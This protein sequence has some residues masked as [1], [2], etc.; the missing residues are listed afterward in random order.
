MKIL[1]AAP[2]VDSRQMDMARVF[3]A[4]GEEMQ[5]RGHVVHYFL[6]EEMPTIRIKSASLLEWGMRVAPLLGRKCRQN[7]YDVVV[8]ASASGWVLS[9][10]RQWLLPRKTKIVSWHH[11]YEACLWPHML[12]DE[13]NGNGKLPKAF[14]IYYN[15]VIWA[16]RQSFLTQDGALFTSTEDRDWAQNQ[17]PMH[18]PKALYQPNGVSSQYY[19][20]ERYVLPRN[21]ETPLPV[22]PSLEMFPLT[23]SSLPKLLF[24]GD[25]LPAR[26]TL[27]IV[28]GRLR[29]RYP[30]LKLSLSGSQLKQDEVLSAFPPDLRADITVIRSH[31]ELDRVEAYQRHDIFIC[32]TLHQG[33]PLAVL[34]AMASAMP[35][36]TTHHNGVQ[37]VIVDGENGL[38]TPK[39]NIDAQVAALSR[40]IESPRLCQSLGLAAFET[41]SRCYTW[42]Q[43][44][45]IFEENLYRVL[46]KKLPLP[47]WMM[48]S[49]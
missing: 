8:M 31:D 23:R 15:A 39:H 20:P 1:F 7:V 21:T 10:Y 28:F 47:D 2:V 19:F 9:T 26:K 16:N 13:K 42:R 18:A 11:G 22:F 24:V 6:E 41:A 48:V 36:V 34:E 30:Q 32:P 40:L 29:E 25:W 44:T 35:V 33:M 37:D 17:Y 46:H 45:D 43:V 49:P 3:R 5:R 27:P 4:I 14:K 12:A 38:L